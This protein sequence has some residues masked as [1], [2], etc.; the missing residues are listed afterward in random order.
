M[1]SLTVKVVD[2]SVVAKSYRKINQTKA[3]PF[4]MLWVSLSL[5]SISSLYAVYFTLWVF[6]SLVSVVSP[7]GA[8]FVLNHV[9]NK[10]T[11]RCYLSL[12]RDGQPIKLQRTIFS[13]A[14][15]V[16]AMSEMYRVTSDA[17]YKVSLVSSKI[18]FH[19]YVP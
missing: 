3:C 14:F 11:G 12:T 18:L 1:L 16:M 2:H 4:H 15:Y 10:D 19:R 17:R 9:K 6:F 13:E 8:E 7:L 5:V